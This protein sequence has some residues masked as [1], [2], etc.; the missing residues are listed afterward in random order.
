MIV[1]D[2]KDSKNIINCIEKML[3]DCREQKN[4]LHCIA[5]L[6]LLINIIITIIM[7]VLHNK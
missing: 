5:S 2:E 7:I 3:L 1:F 6:L 4:H